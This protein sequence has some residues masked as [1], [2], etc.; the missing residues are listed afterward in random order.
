MTSLRRCFIN[1]EYFDGYFYLQMPIETYNE[2][3]YI[4]DMQRSRVDT[5]T[6]RALLAAL[7]KKT[8]PAQGQRG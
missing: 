8:P 7:D 2:F 1:A 5:I 6:A 3:S 4:V